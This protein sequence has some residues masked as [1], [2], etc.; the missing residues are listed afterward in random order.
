[1]VRAC[2]RACGHVLLLEFPFWIEGADALFFFGFS[3]DRV[4]RNNMDRHLE[5]KHGIM[6][7]RKTTAS[8][9]RAYHHHSQRQRYDGSLAVLPPDLL[10][11]A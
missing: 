8:R 4:L 10:L 5:T 7:K 2:V 3:G 1:M 9:R 11:M 6:R